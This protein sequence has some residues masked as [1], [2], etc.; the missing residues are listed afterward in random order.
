MTRAQLI[1]K[2]HCER[3]KGFAWLASYEPTPI[4]TP[5]HFAVTFHHPNCPIVRERKS[6]VMR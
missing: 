3:C 4:N 1:E 6:A 2:V 5:G